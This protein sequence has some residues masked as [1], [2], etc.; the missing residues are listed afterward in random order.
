MLDQTGCSR[1]RSRRRTVTSHRLTLVSG[2]CA[3]PGAAPFRSGAPG[4]DAGRIRYGHRATI[5]TAVRP[6]CGT[7]STAARSRHTLAKR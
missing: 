7:S 5:T 3:A 4:R 6:G 1:Q 2:A